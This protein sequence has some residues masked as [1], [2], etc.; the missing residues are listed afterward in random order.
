MINKEDLVHYIPEADDNRDREPSERWSVEFYPMTAAEQR[1]YLLAASDSKGG[2]FKAKRAS[3]SLREIFKDRIEAVHNL[4]DIKG[5]PIATGVELYDNSETG[6]IDEIFEA[7]T[8]ASTLKKGL[9]KN[10]GPSS[11]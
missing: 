4:E 1:R 9:S 3:E 6:H 11:V 5:R 7:L 8:R 2:G 10:F